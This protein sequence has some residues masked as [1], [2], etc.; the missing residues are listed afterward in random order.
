M[1]RLARL[2]LVAAVVVAAAAAVAASS[3]GGR[4]AA[5]PLIIGID[6]AS[7]DPFVWVDRA[8]GRW[9]MFGRLSPLHT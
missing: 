8:T 1:R 4:S 2:G 6:T 3:S 7:V 9:H 5:T